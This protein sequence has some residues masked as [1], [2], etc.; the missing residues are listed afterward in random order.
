MATKLGVT[1]DQAQAVAYQAQ[2]EAAAETIKRLRA[3][4]DGR[5]GP[6]RSPI[7][8]IG[9]AL[10]MPGG[11]D[12]LDGFQALLR[13][14]VDTTREFPPSRG[15]A[16]S[17]F[18]P[19]PDHP[20]TAYV[21]RGAFLEEVDGFDPAVFGISPR[22]AVGMDPQ[23]RIALELAWEALESAGYAPTELAGQRVG[24]Y[25]G[26]STTDYVRM[27][28]QRGDPAD[29]DAYQL[30]GEPS[31]IAGRISY[32][33]GLR[34]PS[35]VIDT[36]C[37]S[38][39]VA[40]HQACQSLAAGECD[41]ALAGG[42]NLM[43][44]PY[45]FLMMSK[46]RALSADGRC[47]TFDAS[48]DGYARGEG[49]G[50]VV[51]KRLPETAADT[52]LAV[53]RGSAVNHDGRSSGLTVPSPD[54]QQDVIRR[55]LDQAGVAPRDITYVEAHGT[56]TSLGDPIELRALDS[57]LREGRRESEPLLVG[58]VKTNVGHL[59]PAAGVAGL[60][61]VILALQHGEIPPH[62]NLATPN[63]KV[64]WNRLR[65]Q[66]PTSL[67]R[68]PEGRPRVAAVS[69]FGASGTNAHAVVAA[70]TAT[71]GPV[72]PDGSAQLLVLSARTP[73]ALRELS[74]RYAAYLAVAE[75]P[76]ADVCFTSQV[77]R[78]RHAH[79]LAVTGRAADEIAERLREYAR[80][81]TDPQLAE[82]ARG[83]AGARKQGWLFTG[84]GSQ[85]QGMAAELRDEP[86]FAAALGECALALDSMLPV[87]V[88]SMLWGEASPDIDNTGFTQPALFALGYALGRTLMSWGLR[89]SLLLGHS[90]GEITAACLAGALD[91]TDA[92]RLV[93]GRARLMAALPPGGAMAAVSCGE[94]AA[95]V[96]IGDTGVA[97]AA[98]NGLAEIVL[99]GSREPL[100]E[101]ADALSAAGHRVRFLSVSHAFHS[102]LMEP[103]LAEFGDLLATIKVCQPSIPVLSNVTGEPWGPD[104]IDP[105]YWGRHVLATVRFHDGIQRMLAEGV[106]T[107]IE[108]GPR[109]VLTSL[110]RTATD[111]PA[112]AWLPVMSRG[113]SDREGLLRT[114][115]IVHLRG[116]HVEWD[117]VGGS[118]R[119]HRVP[120]PAYPWQRERFWFRELDFASAAGEA[121]DGLGV[122]VRGPEP[123]FE[124]VTPEGEPVAPARS[125]GDGPLAWAA[126]RSVRATSAAL[127]GAW[128]R[129]ADVHADPIL[130]DEARGPWL[131]QTAVHTVPGGAAVTISGACSDAIAAGEPWRRHSTATLA[132][133]AADDEDALEGG[134]EAWG[135]VMRMACAAIADS[136]GSPGWAAGLAEAECDP[137]RA[138][139]ARVVQLREDAAGITAD[140]MLD[141]ADGA[142]AGQI[143]GL[144]WEPVP[145]PRAR[146]Y[147]ADQLLYQLAWIPVQPPASSADAARERVVVIGDCQPAEWI[148]AELRG[149]GTW[150]VTAGLDAE[151]S[152]LPNVTRVVVVAPDIDARDLSAQT[153]TGQVLSAEQ[154]VVR[155]VRRMAGGS[156]APPRLVL[157]TRGAVPGAKQDVRNPAGATL[158]GLGRVIALEHPDCWGGAVDLDPDGAVRPDLVADAVLD[159]GG[160]D[161]I[162]LR[163]DRRLAA[164]LRPPNVR[165]PSATASRWP[166][167]RG[168]VLVT[169]GLGGIGIEIA[170]WLSRSGAGR[171]VLASR[172]ASDAVVQH[173][174]DEG[175]P[176]EAVA[177]DVTDPAAVRSLVGRLAGREVP[178]RGVIHAAGVSAPQDI[179]E[180]DEATYRKVWLPKTVGAWNLHEAS[181]DLDLDFFICMSS[182]AATWGS[183]HLA[184]YAAANNFLDALAF[185]RRALGLPALTVDWGPW[186]VD[187]G[188]YAADV[189]SFLES[190]GLRQ[191]D[192]AQCLS[193]LQ[194]L[195]RAPDPQ[196]VICAVDWRR[197]KPV[198]EARAPRPVLADVDA[199]QEEGNGE[200]DLHLLDRLAA[201][202][203]P[204]ARRAILGEFLHLA[205]ADVIRAE[206]AAV[207]PGADVFALGLDSLMVLEVVTRCRHRLG[208]ALRPSDFFSRSTLADWARHL[209]EVLRGEDLPAGTGGRP[210]EAADDSAMPEISL[211]AIARRAVLPGDIGPVPGRLDPD[212]DRV[213]LTGA[214]GFVGTFLLD[215]LLASTS[216][217]VCCLVRCPDLA[218]GRE[219]VRRAV[220]KYLPWRADAADRVRVVPGDLARP[221]LGLSEPEFARLADQVGAVYHAGAVVDFV[222]TFDQLAPA[223][224]DGTAEIL[225]LAGRGRPKAVHHVSTYG[226]WGLPVPG[227]DRISETDDIRDAGRLVTG[228][229]QTKWGA[230][231]LAVQAQEAGLPVRIFRL[232][233]VLGDS[234]SGVCL[235]THFTCR[236]IK[237]CVQLGL[238]PDLG[239]LE[240]EMTPV[241]YVARALVHIARSRA[242]GAR[243][244]AD[245]AVFHLINPVKMRFSDLVAFIRRSGWQLEVVDRERWWS[246]LQGTV[247]VDRNELHPVMDIV[248]EFVVG[249]E[250][251]INYDVAGAVQALSGS[252]ISCPPLD[253]RLLA[254]YFGY[255][256][257]TGYLPAPPPGE[258]PARPHVSAGGIA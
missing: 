149:R 238:A 187:S 94:A 76:I 135:G 9:A 224:I 29:V 166:L 241:D 163:G 174:R 140:V 74:A 139:A 54:A 124:Q 80:G 126:E 111:D 63:P 79:G 133:R 158:W 4:L 129:L 199:G 152:P 61:K 184:S 202:G 58:S 82:A 91:L 107:F 96:A 99:S 234:R 3:R 145:P 254:T 210:E 92:A 86:A 173:L 130:L 205:V 33:F 16:R 83:P 207:D 191:L 112:V 26:V 100:G 57:V 132:R 24:V 49:A 47:K 115:G 231:H 103:M 102:P 37:S 62:I 123:V 209:D 14:G 64:G 143:T 214:T 84:Q 178:L 72:A 220:Q 221:R 117:A 121:I 93:A 245:G 181:R 69:S 250:E 134:A 5:A 50:I 196:Y 48:A 65:V 247:D 150:C 85:Y 240:I 114:L 239:D 12:T 192:P 244:R 18:H 44:S 237:G 71:A 164:R 170:R 105:A 232:G 119:P 212:P 138:V 56:G 257:R 101:V 67:I 186:A 39:L 183:G 206:A 146:W 222:H 22:E 156:A 97:I 108:I 70:P 35:M 32:T 182:V 218:S 55:A 246:V 211:T 172:S 142:L 15:D 6:E 225:R 137:D 230:D 87:P 2:L 188:L 127:G 60:L 118:R 168:T 46:F 219:R 38:A 23:Q 25:I 153:L 40:V 180:A 36:T 217:E 204:E 248:R 148:A 125:A 51:L 161:Q 128:G 8:I 66:V 203:A 185:H 98:V 68:W 255:Y 189:M 201:A 59:E 144:R 167:R 159:N 78:A 7:A 104:E 90:V 155:L 165:A 243:S 120:G 151:L 73:E 1:A 179:T 235:T 34:G 223:N 131:T 154:L 21:I 19:D 116:G 233:R 95:R 88:E 171:I 197:Y 200:R 45:G 226:I 141:D 31:F 236:V 106:R 190:T 109:P 110:A 13:D 157:L 251:A 227:R 52:V 42:V 258:L 136:T 160:E 253:E 194:R 89:P 169:G 30:V 17:V 195:L 215:E 113:S 249:G 177:L 20:G 41:M 252:G 198:M 228:Y 122:R 11:A 216:A 27:R 77:G 10:R 75:H 43:L 176:V 256:A 229:V 208:V 213:L 242:D 28:Q 81:R 175:M 162:A 53:I 193:L 147:P